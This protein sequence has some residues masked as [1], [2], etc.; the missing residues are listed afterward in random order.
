MG[1]LLKNVIELWKKQTG[2]NTILVNKDFDW[3]FTTQPTDG[4]QP[5]NE[6]Y[7][8]AI[9]YWYYSEIGFD[10][11]VIF[12]KRFNDIY[13][14]NIDK[15]TYLLKST[16]ENGY[17]WDKLVRIGKLAR[18]GADTDTETGTN[19]TTHA[20]TGTDTFQKGVTTTSIQNT[21]N[22]G[23]KLTRNTP[24]ENL[25]VKGTSNT[26]VSDEGADTTLYGSNIKI[27]EKPN[28]TKSKQYNSNFDNDVTETREKLT[29]DEYEALQRIQ[30]I[31]KQFAL[32]FEN[33]FM[34]VI[35]YDNL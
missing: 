6:F 32:L 16:T 3:T 28:V 9:N 4:V 35:N 10:N 21:S 14:D 22:D 5:D 29:I 1:K 23:T 31:Y 2:N 26:T 13:Y 17:N 12:I 30:S 20:K 11:D 7:D 24:N 15:F 25:G 8:R 33:L 18:S 34:G 19:E 27:T